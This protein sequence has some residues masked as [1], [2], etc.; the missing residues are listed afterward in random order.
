METGP[1]LTGSQGKRT[2]AEMCPPA[3]L[4]RQEICDLPAVHIELQNVLDTMGANLA[5]LSSHR[6]IMTL[7]HGLYEER[8]DS[9]AAIETAREIIAT[10]RRPRS[11][12]AQSSIHKNGRENSQPVSAPSSSHVHTKKRAHNFSI[13]IKDRDKKFSGDLGDLG[14]SFSMTIYRYVK[15]II[16]PHNK[17]CN[18]WTIF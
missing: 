3:S 18:I 12:N 6:V 2:I 10:C 1:Q 5:Q 15:T 13:S 14:W 7:A 4:F 9:Q 17:N 11:T 8:E 16:C